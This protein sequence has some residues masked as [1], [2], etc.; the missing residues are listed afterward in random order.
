MRK[1]IIGREKERRREGKKLQ[2]IVAKVIITGKKS[3]GTLFR[4]KRSQEKE[5]NG[6]LLYLILLPS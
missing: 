2:A 5:E 4:T 1:E 6:T 3:N